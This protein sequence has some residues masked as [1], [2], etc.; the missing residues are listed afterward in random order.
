MPRISASLLI[1]AAACPIAIAGEAAAGA[2]L[3]VSAVTLFSSGVGWF[4]HAGAVQGEAKAELRSRTGQI[5]DVLKSLVFQDLDGGSLGAVG[6]P[7]LDPLD[8][9]LKSF[10]VDISGNPPLAG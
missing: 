10:Q 6:S 2:D 1:L 3:P 4:E 9:T 5:N 7:S 8:K